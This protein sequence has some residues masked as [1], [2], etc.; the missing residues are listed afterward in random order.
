MLARRGKAGAKAHAAGHAQV[1][2]QQ[3]LAEIEQ[4]VF[5]PA[6]HGQHML[7]NK[8]LRA[9]TQR[10]AQ[11][12]THGHGLDAGTGNAPGKAQAGDFNFGQFRHRLIKRGNRGAD[13][14]LD[15]D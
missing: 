15:K 3:A 10:P 8:L 6:T 12:F 9:A 11:R 13:K 7:A 4:Q 2:Q 1:N 14:D 5:A